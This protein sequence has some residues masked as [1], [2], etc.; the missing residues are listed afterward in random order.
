[1]EL[2]DRFKYIIKLQNLSPSSF[3]DEIGVQRSSVSHVLSGRNKP[4]M[5]FI[6]KIL[7]RFPKVDAAWLISGSRSGQMPL[8]MPEDIIAETEEPIQYGDKI[9][10]DTVDVEESRSRKVLKI[11]V[12]YD[13][14]TFEEYRHS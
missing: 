4:S 2:I 11:L 6:Q 14:N 9:F 1:M 7:Q 3:A 13:D 5:E 10:P 12:F 8:D